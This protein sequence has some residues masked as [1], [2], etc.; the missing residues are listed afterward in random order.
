MNALFQSRQIITKSGTFETPLFLPVYQPNDAC[1]IEE[2]KEVFQI[3]G[4]ILNSYF[5]YKN[6]PVKLEVLERGIKDYLSFGGLVMSDSGAFQQLRGP[7]YL[8]N[9]KIISFQRDIGVDIASPLDLIS[10]PGDNRSTAAKKL[11]TT[12]KRIRQGLD[13]SGESV[14]AGVQ[15]GGRFLE[16][17]EQS[18]TALVEMGMTYIAL[19]SLVPFFN[20]GHRMDFVG[21]VILQA[22]RICPPEMPLHLYG[23]GDPLELPFYA[24]LGCDVFDSSS[25]VHYARQGWFMTPYGSFSD[26]EALKQAEIPCDSPYFIDAGDSIWDDESL[27]IRHNLWTILQVMDQITKSLNDGS[28]PGHLEHLAEVHQRLFPESQLR[29]S[30]LGL[31][32]DGN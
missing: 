23:S 1:S 21:E 18:I 5:L 17:R 12:L 29:E 26:R 31:N 9:K 6:R 16:L 25:F 13:I 8:S 3:R 32:K 22:R 19:G 2:L 11:G 14:L 24:A 15:Q 20:R 4:L 30:W 28:L 7:L 27:L 10:P